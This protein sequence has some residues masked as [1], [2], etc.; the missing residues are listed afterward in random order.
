MSDYNFYDPDWKMKVIIENTSSDLP[1]N[2]IFLPL[3][4][5]GNKMKSNAFNKDNEFKPQNKDKL[6]N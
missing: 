2:D 3:M 1:K 4:N 5:L 6:N